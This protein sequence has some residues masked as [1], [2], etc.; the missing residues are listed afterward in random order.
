MP[1]G[2][3]VGLS[4]GDFVL[5]GDPAPTPKGAEP[6]PILAHVFC[7][8]TT[9]WVNMPLGTEVGLRLRDIVFDVDPR[10]PRKKGTPTLPNFGPCLCGSMAGWMSAP[11]GTEVDIGPGHIVLDGF[12]ARSKGA[13]QLPLFGPCL[14]WLRSPISAIA[15][16]L[17]NFWS[18]LGPNNHYSISVLLIYGI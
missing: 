9:A 4:P 5:D 6:H 17:S 18:R 7:G 1:L 15:E 11:L 12:P 14:L 16:L 10:Y 13:Q 3:E 8:Q 2:M